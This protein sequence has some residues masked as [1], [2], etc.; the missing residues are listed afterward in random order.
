[1][2]LAPLAGHEPTGKTEVMLVDVDDSAN[3]YATP[4][5]YNTM[6]LR[7]A[8]PDTRSDLNHFDD[9]LWT[10]VVHEYAHVLHLDTIRGPSAILNAIFG[11]QFYPNGTW[12]RWFTEGY[13]VVLETRLS[14]AGRLR[15]S[16]QDMQLRMHVLD[17][18]RLSLPELSGSPLGYPRGGAWYLYGSR[19]LDFI[20]RRHGVE[21]L[22]EIFQ[23]NGGAINPYLLNTRARRHTGYTFDEL[24]GAWVA[25]LKERYDAQLAA[26]GTPSPERALTSD[27]ETRRSARL[28]PDGRTLYSLRASADRMPEL[29]A[30]DLASG[31]ERSV[32]SL[33]GDG[34]LTVLADGRV[35]VSQP[36]VHRQFYAFDDLYLV[37][38][39]RG[40]GEW[41][42]QGARLSEP[43]ASRD[44]RIVAVHR[45]GAG[46]TA[47][48]LFES[49]DDV[50]KQRFR[51]LH[52]SPEH[53]TVASPRWSP[54][55]RHVAFVEHQGVAF[56]LRLLDVATGELRELTRDGSQDL[57]P[58]FSEDGRRVLFSSDRTGIFDVYELEL[59]SGE[60]RRRT[61][62]IGGAF[63]PIEIGGRLHYLRFGARGFDLA[64]Q[65]PSPHVEPAPQAAESP[66]SRFI[67]D[68]DETYPV[69]P[70]SP[71]PTLRPAYWMPLLGS[72]ARGFTLGAFTTGH[73]VLERWRW[74][75]SGWWGIDS[76]EPGYSLS[77]TTNALWP[78]L[79]FSSGRSVYRVA[80]A[81]PGY[82]ES[83]LGARLSSAWDF[84]WPLHSLRIEAG[85]G[86]EF[87]S[88]AATVDDSQAGQIPLSGRLA[89]ATLGIGYSNAR[90]FTRSISIEEGRRLSLGIRGTAPW[91]GSEFSN[92]RVTASWAEYLRNPIPWKPLEHHVLA[93]R[94]VGGYGQGDFG[95]RQLFGLGGPRPMDVLGDLFALQSPTSLLR[96]YP[97][98]FAGSAFW[99]A[100]AEYRFPILETQWGL[101]T[102]PLSLR[103][104]HGAVFSDVGDAFTPEL[105]RT[106]PQVGLGAELRAEVVLGYA[107]VVDWRLGYARGLGPK[108]EDQLLLLVGPHF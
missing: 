67:T 19:F 73:D 100:T 97:L 45:P 10:L 102:L 96:G 12:P 71:W 15:S 3:G 38:P 51:V 66:E 34:V 8:A 23:D 50:R 92:V 59:D 82:A 32:R 57:M 22:R 65:A 75:A 20:A 9:W 5:P 35:L 27:A 25:E 40:R 89:T 4:V 26:V 33:F 103:R 54:D 7:A 46:R 77:V 87:L 78:S 29:R 91:L 60:V 76:R 41:I 90:R 13:A 104:I 94:L 108:G 62:V 16:W 47:I 63:E 88:P 52:E 56:D 101:S 58:A 24:Y 39:R 6:Q 79:T 85:Y 61:R 93:L 14:Q 84:R 95:D 18:E 43:D 99:L 21:S 42:T 49:L 53:E 105:R 31:R 70:Y 37:D 107:L 28:S 98:A 83:S 81:P 1:M 68:S 69:K 36:N 72:D 11:R 48:V 74:S 17:G 44:G 106:V 86:L 30:L 2:L 64:E 55:G 80:N